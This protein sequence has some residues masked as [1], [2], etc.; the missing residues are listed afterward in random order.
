MLMSKSRVRVGRVVAVVLMITGGVMLS[1]CQPTSAGTAPR[2]EARNQPI[3]DTLRSADALASAIAGNL[4]SRLVPQLDERYRYD[5]YIAP[6]RNLD[7]RTSTTEFDLVMRM[8]RRELM[9]NPTFR[10][11]FR[12]LEAPARMQSIA[13]AQRTGGA[14]NN[15]F[16]DDPSLF[17]GANT[18]PEYVM[19]LSGT[20]TPI[21]RADGVYYD[22]EISVTRLSNGEILLTEAF[23][24]QFGRGAN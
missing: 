18:N 3:D 12:V 17:E 22:T 7:P 13:Q 5:L 24:V 6:F 14:S 23:G 21:R 19:L 16:A 8:V 1:G 2:P 4:N 9:N 20:F 15:P 11:T 10:E